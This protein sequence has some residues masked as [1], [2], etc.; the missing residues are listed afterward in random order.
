MLVGSGLNLSGPGFRNVKFP[1][2]NQNVV[3]DISAI[4]RGRSPSMSEDDNEKP[5]SGLLGSA[6]SISFP[7]P[8]FPPGN[9]DV[10][11]QLTSAL[12]FPPP[13]FTS[14]S[15][16]PP[17]LG[18]NFPPPQQAGFPNLGNGLLPLFPNPSGMS[19]APGGRS[20]VDKS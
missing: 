12:T 15:I 1:T 3:K 11:S 10:L 17:L 5:K 13:G 6:Q 14:T 9:G 2:H 4:N 20:Q 7:P 18:S 8:S 19:G 16:P